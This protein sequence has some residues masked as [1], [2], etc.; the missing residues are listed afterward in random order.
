MTKALVPPV[1]RRF[2]R[3][4]LG[5]SPQ[6]SG[7]PRPPEGAESGCTGRGFLGAS[8]PDGQPAFWSDTEGPRD[9]GG[10]WG[11]AVNTQTHTHFEWV[12]YI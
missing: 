4:V 11:P 1:R 7:P 12:T 6:W 8:Q 10:H 3:R 2:H 5:V 9:T